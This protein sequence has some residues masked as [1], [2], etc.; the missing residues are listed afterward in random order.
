MRLLQCLLLLLLA[1]APPLR[2]GEFLP[3][4]RRILF[5]GDSIT[6]ASQYVDRFELFLFTQFPGRAFEVINCGLASETVS[7]LSEEGHAGG[8]FPRPDLHERLERVLAKVQPDLVFAC[9]GMNDGIYLPLD[10]GRTAKFQNGIRRLEAAVAKHGAKLI[11][12]TPPVFDPAQGQDRAASY[13]AVLTRYSEWLLEQ[14]TAGWQVIDLHGPM[15]AALQEQRKADPAFTFSKDH[16]H[17]NDAGHIVLGDALLAGLDPGALPAF[18]KLASGDWA[19]SP[20]GHEFLGKIHRRGRILGEAWLTET[21]HL[22]PGIPK[23]LPLRQAREAAA[24]LEKQ[25]RASVPRP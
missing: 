23:G 19:R 9:Y 7:G 6:Q 24:E 10:A 20:E 8:Q 14:R 12:L 22:R 2:A 4:V 25:L 1:G 17:P 16:V 18:Q 15:L 21:G 13:D 3:G 11:L 5:L